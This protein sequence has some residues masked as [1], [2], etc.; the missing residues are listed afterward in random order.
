MSNKN[1]VVTPL[2]MM[3]NNALPLVFIWPLQVRDNTCIKTIKWR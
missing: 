1:K 3:S 2:S